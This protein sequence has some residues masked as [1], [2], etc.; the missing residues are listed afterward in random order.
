MLV[1]ADVAAALQ[2]GSGDVARVYAAACVERMAQ[3]F[4]G[5]RA[6]TPG[7]DRDVDLYVDTLQR[8]WDL[9]DPLD[10]FTARVQ[11]L[12]KFPELEPTETGHTAVGDIYAFYSVLALRYATLC[13]G[14]GSAAEAERCGHAVLT[15]MGQ[16]DQNVAQA[17]FYQEEQSWQRRSLPGAEGPVDVD[18]LRVGCAE[19]SRDRLTVLT[20]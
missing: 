4:T 5:L 11:R 7:R 3:I 6:G 10:N 17:A 19:V 20:R 8:L 14:S 2:S 18:A 1:E 16:L 15:A 13:A 9:G 12:E